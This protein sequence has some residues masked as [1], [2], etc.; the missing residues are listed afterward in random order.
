MLQIQAAMNRSSVKKS[1][2]YLWI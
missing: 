2:W 1:I